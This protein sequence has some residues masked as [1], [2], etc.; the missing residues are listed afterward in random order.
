LILLASAL[1]TLAP[2][3]GSRILYPGPPIH[4]LPFAKASGNTARSVTWNPKAN[5]STAGSVPAGSTTSSD[6]TS[7]ILIGERNVEIKVD[8]DSVGQAE[9]FQVTAI[10]TGA[11][12]SLSIYLDRSSASTQLFL[13][14][15]SDSATGHPATLLGQSSSTHLTAGAWNT[16]QVPR[17]IVGKGG[18]YWIAL[19]GVRGGEPAFRD[20]DNADCVSEKSSQTDLTTLPAGWKT[21]TDWRNSCPLSAYGFGSPVGVLIA[22]PNSVNFGD[23]IVGDSSAL[24]VMLTNIG[25][26]SLTISAATHT[27]AGFGVTGLLLPLTLNP[28]KGA[29]FSAD[30]APTVTGHTDGDI[31][32]VSDASDLSLVVPLAGAGVKA[33]SVTLTWTASTSKG[34]MG[35]DVY[36]GEHSGGPYTLLNSVLIAGT[37]YKDAAVQA[38]ETYYYVVTAVN[39]DHVKSL[40]SNQAQAVVPFP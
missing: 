29:N 21:G 1:F 33:H 15:Y 28:G 5:D 11:V 14:I 40:Q 31:S 6:A 19:L 16:F 27:G 26:A 35:Y 30:F 32:I 2:G 34:V 24:P 4:A 7:T 25:T 38:G 23:I 9:A 37:S 3:Q 36:R 12:G 17:I 22:R 18:H 39:S 20:R 10:N 8:H 13:G